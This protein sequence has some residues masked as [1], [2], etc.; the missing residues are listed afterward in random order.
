MA[1]IP[2]TRTTTIMAAMIHCLLITMILV[3]Y[4]PLRHYGFSSHYWGFPA[5]RAILASTPPP[6]PPSLLQRVRPSIPPCASGSRQRLQPT[7]PHGRHDA[8]SPDL[9]SIWS[10]DTAASTSGHSGCQL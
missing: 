3:M 1:T 8:N 4:K 7:H 5:H 9:G 6:Q 10:S 2:A